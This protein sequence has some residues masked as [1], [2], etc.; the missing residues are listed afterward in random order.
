[1]RRL[2]DLIL[3]FC[4]FAGLATGAVAHAAELA[5][6]GEV[7]AATEWLHADGDHDEVPADTDKGYPHH[8]NSCHGHDLAAPLKASRPAGF[9][10][11]DV[12]RPATD[13]ARA[14]GPPA[15]LL[16]PPIA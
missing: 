15:S 3:A 12:P 8:H 1:M 2:F 9:G 5:G 7:T 4:L 11:A 10:R 13:V 16:R 14:S 6:N